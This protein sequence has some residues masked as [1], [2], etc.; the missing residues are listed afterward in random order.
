[1]LRSIAFGAFLLTAPLVAASAQRMAEARVAFAVDA[2]TVVQAI[3]RVKADSAKTGLGPFV[4]VGALAGAACGALWYRDAVEKAD[5]W[6]HPVAATIGIG[7]GAAGGALA[8]LVTAF[9]V[10]ALRGE[11]Y[12]SRLSSEEL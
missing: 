1:M 2:P 8:G 6:G 5:G 12:W 7:G 10:R 11:P 3:P 4:V 9:I